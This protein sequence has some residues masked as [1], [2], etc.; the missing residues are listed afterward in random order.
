MRPDHEAPHAAH[1]TGRRWL[2]LTLAL[3]AMFVSI[4]SLAVAVHHG[5]AMDRLVAANS[6]PFLM[7]STSNLDPQGNRRISLSVENAGVGPARI[8][9]FEVWWQGQPVSNAPELLSRCCMADS[10]A[11]IDRSTARALH[12]VLGEIASRVMRA[13]DVETLLSLELMDANA[14]IWRRLDIARFHIKMRA[15]YCSVFD[16]CWETDLV[17]TSARRIGTCPAA[18]VPFTIPTRWFESP[19]LAGSGA[20]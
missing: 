13:G 12:L 18:K 1:A 20:H 8:Q 10:K 7:Y 17:Q 9:T 5:N 16:E 6:W 3:S 14:D 11:Q 15:C 2:D 4:V 19:P